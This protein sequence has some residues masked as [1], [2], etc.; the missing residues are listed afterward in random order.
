MTGNGVSGLSQS[1]QIEI[2]FSV[3]ISMGG[4]GVSHSQCSI[5]SLMAL[6]TPCGMG[7]RDACGFDVVLR[8]DFGEGGN[9]F[10]DNGFRHAVHIHRP[11]PAY[12]V[13]GEF[14]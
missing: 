11:L 7:G 2:L 1:G 13:S 14:G 4:H 10:G 12:P 3:K 6:S 9:S 5:S 8:D